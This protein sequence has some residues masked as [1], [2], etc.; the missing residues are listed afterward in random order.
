MVR[1]NTNC[2]CFAV[3]V[4]GAGMPLDRGFERWEDASMAR[5]VHP[6]HPADDLEVIR[7][8]M[9]VVNCNPERVKI[10][11]IHGGDDWYDAHVDYLILPEGMDFETEKKAREKWYA[12]EFL[13]AVHRGEHPKNMDIGDWLRK[14][15]AI[16]PTEEQLTVVYDND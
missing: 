10:T 4:K 2:D 9:E 14:R 3:R 16:D 7:I 8:R 13:P 5:L 1:V 11:A 15:G 12:D 6:K